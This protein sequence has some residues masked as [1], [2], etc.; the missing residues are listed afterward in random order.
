MKPHLSSSHIYVQQ[1]LFNSSHYCNNALLNGWYDNIFLQRCTAVST[2]I[3]HL[4]LPPWQ[5][6][7]GESG[8]TTKTPT[9]SARR[10]TH[11][12]PFDP[13]C[14][15]FSNRFTRFLFSFSLKIQYGK[16]RF[17]TFSSFFPD[18]CSS[19]G[20]DSGGSDGSAA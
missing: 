3:S 1:P 9:Q 2:M 8:T 13:L 11:L 16:T 6:A 17:L 5:S 12:R 10:K 4:S 18:V 20:R 19:G 7:Y 15:T 14:S